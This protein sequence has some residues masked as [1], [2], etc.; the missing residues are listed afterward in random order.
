M[1][2]TQIERKAC[3]PLEQ[4]TSIEFEGLEHK[5]AQ[6]IRTEI[7][8][9]FDFW[10]RVH[11]GTGFLSLHGDVS[12]GRLIPLNFQSCWHLSVLA[13]CCQGFGCI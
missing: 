9:G 4:Q 10:R 13:V 2:V 11:F 12:K 1:C 5:L 8:R 7:A 6:D 3:E